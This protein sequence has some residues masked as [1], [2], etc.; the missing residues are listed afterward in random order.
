MQ[1]FKECYLVPKALY[2]SL[3]KG[4]T[5]KEKTMV[6]N[7]KSNLPSN[8][9]YDTP[10]DVKTKYY[11]YDNKFPTQSA[12]NPKSHRY[13]LE[14][15]LLGNL[16]SIGK[17]N[18]AKDIVNFIISRTGGTIEWNDDFK[19]EVDGETLFDLDLRDVL[20]FIVGEQEDYYGKA[21]PIITKL[22]ELN[23][24]SYFFMFYKGPI[25]VM[26]R[27]EQKYDQKYDDDE[28][29][30]ETY[31]YMRDEKPTY[32]RDVFSRESLESDGSEHEISFRPEDKTERRKRR[33]SDGSDHEII[34]RPGDKQERRQRRHSADSEVS[35]K[36]KHKA[37]RKGRS[38]PMNLRDK[39]IKGFP[40][41]EGLP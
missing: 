30:E 14:Y 4:K 18:V 28:R 39:T 3:S 35:F 37:K 24:P 17:K 20:A 2:E 7:S 5:L 34:L 38:H 23:A 10:A 6:K 11:D 21:I 33:Y 22:Q 8:T 36:I 41:W 16:H 19:L 27:Y 9:N 29:Y 31:Q 25:N 26:Q 1:S 15:E 40:K 32:E 13:S 12:P